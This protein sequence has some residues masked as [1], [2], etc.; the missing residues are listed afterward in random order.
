MDAIAVSAVVAFIAAAI[1]ICIIKFMEYNRKS[2]SINSATGR[3]LS[4]EFYQLKTEKSDIERQLAVELQKNLVIPELYRQISDLN[5][6]IKN[7]RES[8]MKSI[9]DIATMSEA[10]TNAKINSQ[11]ALE[12]KQEIEIQF[13]K[14]SERIEVLI[15]EK[16]K[17]ENSLFESF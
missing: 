9:V 4:E 2:T 14:Y 12:N 13:A 11:I 1:I 5:S 10:L 8:E 16:S 7:L 6:E 15:S 17:L 3:D